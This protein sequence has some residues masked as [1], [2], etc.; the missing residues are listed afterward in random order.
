VASAVGLLKSLDI[1][2]IPA[3]MFSRH[4]QASLLEALRISDGDYDAHM[5]IG[6]WRDWNWKVG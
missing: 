4:L 6:R 2:I 5:I 3:F 1:A